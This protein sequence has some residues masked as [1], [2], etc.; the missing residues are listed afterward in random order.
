M[1]PEGCNVPCDKCLT[2]MGEHHAQQRNIVKEW[3]RDWLARLEANRKH[4]RFYPILVIILAG[5]IGLFWKTFDKE[6][7]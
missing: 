6:D 7:N 5:L 1:K 3:L 4:Q 2:G